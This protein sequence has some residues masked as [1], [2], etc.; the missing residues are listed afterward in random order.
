MI[1]DYQYLKRQKQLTISYVTETGG[2]KILNYNVA[3]F[4]TFYEDENGKYTN[5]N[6]KKCSAKYTY[7]PNAYDIRTFIREL[8]EKDR[9]KLEGKR[10]PRLYTFDIEVEVSKEEFPEPSESK[11]PIQT[12]SIVSD[13]LDVIVFGLKEMIDPDNKLQKK[14]NE[15]LFKSKF[16]TSFKGQFNPVIK[17]IKFDS[18]R[19]MLNYFLVNIVSKAPVIAGWN[20]ILFDWQYI[21]NRVKFYYPDIMFSK[22]SAIGATYR[23][24]YKD[25]KGQKVVLDMP[26]HTLVLDMMDIIG[27]FDMMVMP[28][29]ESLS[30]DYISYN[31]IGL[32]KIKY[33]G[34]LQKLYEEDFPTY[35]FYNAIDSVLVQLIDM[36]FKTLNILEIQALLINDK[37]QTAF[38]KIAITEALFFNH[39]YDEGIKIVEP[40]K[41]EG[42]RGELQGAYVAT[43][44]SGLHRF[45]CCNDF[46]SLYPSTVITCNISVE[47]YIG[48]IGK[49]ITEEQGEIYRKDKNYFVAVNGCVFKNDKDYAFKCIEKKLKAKRSISKY[50]SKKLDSFVISDID[51]IRKGR[52]TSNTDYPEDVVESLKGL[53]FDIKNAQDI[54]DKIENLDDFETVVKAEVTYLSSEEIAFKYCANAAYGGSSHVSFSWFS[55]ELASTIT[56]EA[57]NLIHLMEHHIPDMI[58]NNWLNMTELHKKLGIEVVKN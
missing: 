2:K 38:S 41:F 13:K 23:K 43:P 29:K 57:R 30:L 8:P 58:N 6:G 24:M 3:R 45:L 48:T 52:A 15:Y 9:K 19:E 20:S 46:S 35:I 39:W 50:L 37:I 25:M 53:G 42:E 4:K 44:V 5:W 17:Y 40:K 28:I 12:I 32:H 10:A 14:Y 21:M 16:F 34:D 18:E 54:K 1:L 31:T 36:K 55:M 56:A 49:N 11:Y 22:C 26:I 47:N 27:T 51:H 33:K 7:N